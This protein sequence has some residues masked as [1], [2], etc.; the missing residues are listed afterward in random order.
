MYDDHKLT[1]SEG[2]FV[3][4]QILRVFEEWVGDL[5]PDLQRLRSEVAER[6]PPEADPETSHIIE[7]NW[8]TLLKKAETSCSELQLLIRRKRDEIQSLRDGVCILQCPLQTSLEFTK[9]T[10]DFN[11]QLY[12]TIQVREAR[13]GTKMNEIM[14]LF[15]VATILY[16][17]AT[18]V[19]VNES[20]FPKSEISNH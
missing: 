14:L 3:A 9:L 2:Y 19:A 16:L 20:P 15:T 7:S 6:T 12:N 13:K 8:V 10:V 11:L 18:F 17:P 1:A 4:N 5:E